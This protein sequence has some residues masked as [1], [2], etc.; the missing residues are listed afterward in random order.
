M[1][2]TRPFRLTAWLACLAMLMAALA[3]TLSRALAAHGGA[4]RLVMICTATGVRF[5]DARQGG[6]EDPA[7][8]TRQAS[9]HD[10]CPYCTSAG[11]APALP[12]GGLAF[13]DCSDRTLVRV[14]EPAR[15]ALPSDPIT[16]PFAR[17]P[18]SHT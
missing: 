3:P 16:A 4:D 17:G 11:Q 10:D 8:P 18:P 1:S 2:R 13:L 7:S 14:R 6:L 12:A 5:V 9:A 15:P